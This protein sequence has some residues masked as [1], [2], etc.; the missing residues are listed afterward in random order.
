MSDTTMPTTCRQELLAGHTLAMRC[1]TLALRFLDRARAA[2]P[3]TM[4]LRANLEALRM[5]GLASRLMEGVGRIVPR[6]HGVPLTAIVPGCGTQNAGLSRMGPEAGRPG[7]SAPRLHAARGQRRGT[8]KN[9]NP[10]GDYLQAP[11]C[12]ARTRAGC[13]CR[14]PAMPNGRCRLHGGLSTGPRTPE[15]RRR[16]Q[17]ARLAHGYRS[18][19][20]I[21]LRSRAVH[22]ARR[23]RALTAPARS[24][25]HGVHRPDSSVGASGARPLSS[26]TMSASIESGTNHPSACAARPYDPFDRPDSVNRRDAE[27]QRICRGAMFEPLPARAARHQSFSA[28]LR[29]CGESFAGHGVDR[30]FRDPLRSSA[31]ALA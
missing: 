21:G 25:G 9:G 6:L 18:A 22:A 29:L 4:D 26:P 30:S 15:G 24:A 23:L 3:G 28:S 2:E 19:A 1:G 7:P 16:A 10:C 13:P 14:Q 31:A 11:R 27:A 12:G 8:L 17:T 20:L 5:G